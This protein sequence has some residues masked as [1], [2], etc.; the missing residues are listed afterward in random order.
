MR[1]PYGPAPFAILLI[2]VLSGTGLAVWAPL[3]HPAGYQKPDLVLATFVAEQAAVYRDAL[4]KFE[5]ENHCVVQVEV[6]DQKAL[7]SRLQSALQVGAEVP[8]L[9]ELMYGTMGIFTQGPI[10]DVQ[11]NDLTDRIKSS[12]LYDQLVTNRLSKWSSRGHVFALPHNVHPVM[13]AYRRDLVGQLGIDVNQ[14]TTWDDFSA[15]GRELV[16]K[17][18][19]PDGVPEHYMI[20]LPTDGNDQLI[21]LLLQHGIGLFDAR[22][23][24]AFDREGALDVV[25]WFVKQIEGKGRISFPCGEGQ[26]FA[27][28]VMDGLCLFYFC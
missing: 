15:A 21:L 2:A 7:Q 24:V 28:A 17:S 12:G 19:R 20:D 8:D 6:V 23:D 16:R 1:F 26:N 18:M 22:G 3:S 13:L 14:L 9:V 5:A 10:E 25:C 4:P 11:L 27:H